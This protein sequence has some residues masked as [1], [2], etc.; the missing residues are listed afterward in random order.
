MKE[1]GLLSTERNQGAS[2]ATLPIVGAAI[3]AV[4]RALRWR[5]RWVQRDYRIRRDSA[6][7]V[8]QSIIR[9]Q[10]YAPWKGDVEF[11]RIYELAR[12]NTLVDIVRCY[13]L[14]DLAHNLREIPGAIL[15]VGVWRGGT[16]A[17]LASALA[18]T[19]PGESIYLC[20]TFRGVVKAGAND[21]TYRG[22]EHA[23]TS[24]ENVR[25]LL[26]SLSISN[27]VLLE[28]MFPED[29]GARIPS[30]AIALCHIDVDV[31]QSA[32]DTVEWVEPRLSTGG[33][34]VF[35]DYGFPTCAGVTR[36][37][38]E[39]RETRRWTAIYNLNGHAILIKR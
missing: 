5:L 19:K 2:L 34:L 38:H 1:I 31:Y 37:V 10:A 12:A 3:R 14:W 22:G 21:T 6:T 30:G 23:D 26:R 27:A 9:N 28:G 11:L 24:Q 17:I 7:Y 36:L 33:A 16:A 32:R 25:S 15:E 20:D 29:T 4:R 13:E 18:Y 8:Y 39:L 35:D